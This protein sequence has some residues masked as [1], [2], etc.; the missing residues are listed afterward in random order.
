[1]ASIKSGKA[2]GLGAAKLGSRVIKYLRGD[3]KIPVIPMPS[4]FGIPV[5]ELQ[6]IVYAT[7]AIDLW[8]S[9]D[10]AID[11]LSKTFNTYWAIAHVRND[12][13]YF[14]PKGADTFE[15]YQKCIEGG[16]FYD[17][18]LNEHKFFLHE[19]VLAPHT[20]KQH[21]DLALKYTKNV[22]TSMALT[23][24]NMVSFF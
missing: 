13:E 12:L 5:S 23:P 18:I 3:E 20:T 14:G 11:W 24:M 1:M 9:V 15:F 4:S 6:A 2:A 16:V 21:L 10:G 17:Q 7:S 19:I 22:N 8:R